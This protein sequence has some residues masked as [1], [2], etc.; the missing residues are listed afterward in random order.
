MG[1]KYSIISNPLILPSTG[2]SGD[3]G[4]A[5]LQSGGPRRSSRLDLPR[6][7][8]LES[9]S[10]LN[11][12]RDPAR[13]GVPEGRH[14]STCPGTQFSGIGLTYL[15]LPGDLISRRLSCLSLPG[16]LHPDL[17]TPGSQVATVLGRISFRKTHP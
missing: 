12:L 14:A 15:N 3:L 11:L 10:C 4:D 2:H 1:R 6:D 8:V 17:G 7:L 9:L 13:P 16:D 5:Q